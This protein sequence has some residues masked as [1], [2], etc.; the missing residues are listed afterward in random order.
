MPKEEEQQHKLSVLE[1]QT[2][3]QD[4][5]ELAVTLW[6]DENEEMA[7]AGRQAVQDFYKLQNKY[8]RYID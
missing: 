2:Q 3:H 1:S 7:W 6:K 4:W 5:T 8:V